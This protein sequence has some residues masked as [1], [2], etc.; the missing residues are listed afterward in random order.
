MVKLAIFVILIALGICLL[1]QGIFHLIKLLPTSQPTG[2]RLRKRVDH[3]RKKVGARYGFTSEREFNR[4]KKLFHLIEDNCL[5]RAFYGDRCYIYK[6]KVTE[7]EFNYIRHRATK[8][9]MRVMYEPT[10]IKLCWDAVDI[11]NREP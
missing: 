8:A 11:L 7:A 2:T 3:H 6:K 9:G 10:G 1:I 4:A 5:T